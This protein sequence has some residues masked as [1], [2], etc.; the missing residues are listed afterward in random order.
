MGSGTLLSQFL[1]VFLPTL[2]YF[3]FFHIFLLYCGDQSNVTL[4]CSCNENDV[5]DMLP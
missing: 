2:P 3:H 4:V 5:M 1:R